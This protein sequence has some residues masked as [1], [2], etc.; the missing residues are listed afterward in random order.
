MHFRLHLRFRN[1]PAAFVC[2][3]VLW[4][5]HAVYMDIVVRLVFSESQSKHG[6]RG[7]MHRV[8][9]ARSRKLLVGP[10]VRCVHNYTVLVLESI[11]LPAYSPTSS[12]HLFIYISIY[13]SIYLSIYGS[14]SKH[15]VLTGLGRLVTCNRRGCLATSPCATNPPKTKRYLEVISSI[16]AARNPPQRV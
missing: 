4:C 6:S 9:Q 12:I 15:R 3:V 10:A 5:G 14:E 8:M 13:R 11:Y 16:I 1:L 2:S 7:S